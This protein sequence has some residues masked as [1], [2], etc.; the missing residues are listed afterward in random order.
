VAHRHAAADAV[1]VAVTVEIS[2]GAAVGRTPGAAA[3][4]D[5]TLAGNRPGAV[6]SGRVA[7]PGISRGTP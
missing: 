3:C 7:D 1:T 5:S 6:R 4:H 2:V